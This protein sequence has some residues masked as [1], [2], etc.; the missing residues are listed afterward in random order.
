MNAPNPFNPSFGKVPP[1]FIDRE[2]A[3]QT[4]TEGLAD[5]NSPWQ[6]TMICGVRGV[7][8]TAVLAEIC[9]RLEED[10]GGLS[11]IFLPTA[12]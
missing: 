11:R 2:Q 8:K 1:V 4:L 10:P 5:R 12:M 9:R 3:V 7:G 6:T